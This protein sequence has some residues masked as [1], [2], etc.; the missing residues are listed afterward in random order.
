MKLNRKNFLKIAGLASAGMMVRSSRV[1]ANA[2]FSN[3]YVQKFNMHGYAA[4]KLNKVRIGII[5]LGNRGT[6][7]IERFAQVEDVEIKALCD[8]IPERVNKAV[9][10]VKKF[11]HSPEAYSGDENAWKKLCERDDIDLVLA[12]TPWALHA[13]NAIYAMEHGKHVAIEIPGVKTI[14][15]CWQIV[16]TSERTKKH[17]TLLANSA[18]GD[19]NLL[20]LNMAREGF[21]GEII[22]GEGAYIHDRV[23]GNDRWERDKE[24]DNWFLYRPWRLKENINRNGN[25]YAAHGLGTICQVMDLNYGDK[26]DYMVSMSGNDFSMAPK[27]KEL[28]AID[29]YYKAFVGLNFRGNMNTSIIRTHKGRTIM[30]QHDISSPRPNVRF[31]MISGTKAI[32]QETP[33]PARIATSHEGWLSQDEFNSLEE[34]YKPE[35]I[36]K[37]GD[38]A[39]SLGGHGGVDAMV[40]WRIVD[41][42]RNGIPLDIDVY[43]AALWSSIV[44][45]SEW[46]VANRSNSVEVPDFTAGAW[47]TNERGMDINLRRGGTT[48]FI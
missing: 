11:S 48:K 36:K 16:E 27:M 37:V 9:N 4:P 23:T 32:A 12:T 17:C 26:M 25:L 1:S 44:P 41:C 2:P 45:L 46:S 15:E 5:G 10:S 28:A 22:H 35:I 47:K 24:N 18:Y 8:L 6:G 29:D 13:P 7:V 19:F 14:E 34:K 39:K 31:N 43:D 20:I 38:L 40:A 30:L 33:L 3:D 21:F 42:L